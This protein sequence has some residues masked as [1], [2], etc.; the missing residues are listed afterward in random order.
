MESPRLFG[1]AGE[2][3]EIEKRLDGRELMFFALSD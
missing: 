1:P 2:W 3:I